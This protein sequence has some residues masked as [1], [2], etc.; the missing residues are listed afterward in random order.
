MSNCSCIISRRS[1]VLVSDIV[2]KGSCFR[3][4]MF[5]RSCLMSNVGGGLGELTSG[6]GLT[7]G[8]DL[9]LGPDFG[10]EVDC[11]ARNLKCFFQFIGY[12]FIGSFFPV[13]LRRRRFMFNGIVLILWCPS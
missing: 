9:T 7:S 6:S 12:R 13:S 8:S 1:A 10:S 3:G 11:S 5:R 4:L 2:S